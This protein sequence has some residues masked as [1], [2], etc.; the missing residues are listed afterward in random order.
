MHSSPNKQRGIAMVIAISIMMIG[1]ITATTLLAKQQLSLRKGS[2]LIMRDQAAEYNVAAEKWAKLWLAK[3]DNQYDAA[4]DDWAT[5][6][7]PLP[8]D[9]GVI[10]AQLYDL[11]GRININSFDAR[12]IAEPVRKQ[13]VNPPT[14]NP[15]EQQQAI[16]NE[17]ALLQNINPKTAHIKDWIDA[18]DTPTASSGAET[19]T[20]MGMERPY[21]AANKQAITV[22]EYRLLPEVTDEEYQLFREPEQEYEDPRIALTALP[23][24]TKI[25]LNF[26]PLSLLTAIIG[27]PVAAEQ[28]YEEIQV[29]PFDNLDKI[30]TSLQSYNVKIEGEDGQNIDFVT[31]EIF[32]V[33]SNYFL[34]VSKTYIGRT[35]SILYSVLYRDAQKKVRVINRSYGTI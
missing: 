4:D 28:L 2:N 14:P 9:G 6:L 20:Y 1:V 5:E 22:S 10:I 27:D 30:T 33:E 31:P 34:L 12:D 18:D 23:G 21:R 13:N 35:Q 17:L 19:N 15:F 26:A 11:Q 3:D 8:V 24:Y 7:P 29:T 32:T 16:Y 25:N